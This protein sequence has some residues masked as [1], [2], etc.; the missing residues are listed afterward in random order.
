VQSTWV[1][2]VVV[3]VAA[4]VAC[5][6]NKASCLVVEIACLVNGSSVWNGWSM[7]MEEKRLPVGYVH[8]NSDG[9]VHLKTSL[10][11]WAYVDSRLRR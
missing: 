1:V 8:V 5:P 11:Y 6:G 3:V 7:M 4:V 9:S 2:V 10:R